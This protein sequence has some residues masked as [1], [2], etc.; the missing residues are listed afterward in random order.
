MRRHD[1]EAPFSWHEV[2][3]GPHLIRYRVSGPPDGQPMVHVHGFA[4]SGT[5]LLPTAALLA[6]QYR[7]FVPDLPGFGRSPKPPQ[8]LGIDQMGAALGLFMDAVGLASA[9]LVGNSLG[10]AVI[11]ELIYSA[12]EKVDRAVMVGLAGGKQNQPLARAVAQMA[13]DGLRE[14]PRLIPVAV[15]D[16]LRFGPGRA[17]RLFSRMAAYPVVDR[18]MQIPVPVLVVIG[19]ED[20]LRP[21]WRRIRRLLD[22]VPPQVR[23]VLL[24]GAAHAINFTHPNELA[25]II[26]QYLADGQIRMD[27]ADP[28]GLPVLELLRPQLGPVS[29][30]RQERPSTLS[31]LRS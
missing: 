29:A 9:V 24:Q 14:P 26:R 6:E 19:S 15:P 28:D 21:S 18:F 5:Y 25:S 12:P 4:I 8:A 20:P 10:C 3:A 27:A 13:I 31:L 17:V 1:P 23:L 7:V 16:Y 11:T 30:P 22:R 2:Q